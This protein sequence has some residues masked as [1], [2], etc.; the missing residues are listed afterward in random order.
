MHIFHF[1]KAAKFT[2]KPVDTICDTI[3]NIIKKCNISIKELVNGLIEKYGKDINYVNIIMGLSYFE[4][5]ENEILPKTFIEYDWENI[6]KFFI[7]IQDEF[8]DQL[9]KLRSKIKCYINVNKV[10]KKDCA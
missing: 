6:K 10:C 5:A 3:Y 8:Q 9:E 7:N 1:V 2:L 4:D